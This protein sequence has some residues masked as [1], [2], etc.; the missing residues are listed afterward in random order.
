MTVIQSGSTTHA[1]IGN[2]YN[3]RSTSDLARRRAE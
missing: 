2:L 1:L 3:F